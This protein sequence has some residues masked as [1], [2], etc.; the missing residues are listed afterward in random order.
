MNS[1]GAEYGKIRVR[2][3]ELSSFQRYRENTQKKKSSLFT[4]GPLDWA[5]VRPSWSQLS[6][7]F[8]GVL[9]ELL[10]LQN[11]YMQCHFFEISFMIMQVYRTL[12]L[13]PHHHLHPH[14]GDLKVFCP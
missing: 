12:I 6:Q 4:N 10:V 14:I 9:S 7:R 3:T 8:K 13:S 2:S 5:P 11:L 1:P